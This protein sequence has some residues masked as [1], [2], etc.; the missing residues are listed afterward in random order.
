MTLCGSLDVRM[1]ADGVGS[2]GDGVAR[3][4]RADESA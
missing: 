3:G 2:E 4:V 1:G